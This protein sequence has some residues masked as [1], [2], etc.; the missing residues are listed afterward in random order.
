MVNTAASVAQ[1]VFPAVPNI[2][3][4][5]IKKAQQLH[6]HVARKSSAELYS[7]IQNAVDSAQASLSSTASAPQAQQGASYRHL[8]AFLRD[9]DPID[10]WAGLTRITMD[11]GGDPEA[12]QVLWVCR[13]CLLAPPMPP[14][15]LQRNAPD[16][17][18]EAATQKQLEAPATEN[19]AL[20]QGCASEELAQVRAVADANAA[21]AARWRARAEALEAQLAAAMQGRTVEAVGGELGGCWGHRPYRR[22][23]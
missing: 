9:H 2:P 3:D 4:A 21:E 5:V 14:T 10:D 7:S 23:G 16:A 1:F 8:R 20:Q 6:D 12:Q 13:G 17:P 11:G 22:A 18:G 15:S 19:A